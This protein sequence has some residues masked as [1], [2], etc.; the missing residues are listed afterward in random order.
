LLQRARASAGREINGVIAAAVSPRRAHEGSIDLAATLELVDFLGDRGC[1]GI[2]LL[3]STGEFVHFAADDRRHMV[4]FAAKRSR[5]PLLVNVSHSTLDG[6]VDLAR[7]AGED[8]VAGV[9]I[10]PPY[11]F[12]Y[13]QA[14]IRAFLLQFAREINGAVPIY[15][16]NIPMFTNPLTLETAREL[17]ETGLYAGIKDSSGDAEYLTGL[18][19]R[20]GDFEI[21]R[22]VGRE[23]LFTEARI[24]GISGVISG[25][26]SALPELLVAIDR[27]ICGGDLEKARALDRYLQEFH[28]NIRTYP[29]PVAIIEA[30]RV[31][32]QKMGA[33]AGPMSEDTTR[34]LAE[35]REWLSG[36]LPEVLRQCAG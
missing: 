36:W 8:G 22:F 30:L 4:R 16:Y 3:G 31:R 13:E 2:A 17:L 35:F 28:E 32:R 23:T 27:A 12:R 26:A 7:D 14:E 19:S 24:G 18:P 9:M 6:A 20:V 25:I 33:F 5:V 15:L 34:R 21:R 11:Y 10:M 1:N 29:L